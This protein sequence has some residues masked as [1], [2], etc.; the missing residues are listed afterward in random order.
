MSTL[1]TISPQHH[2]LLTQCATWCRPIN[3]LKVINQQF[4]S[5]SQVVPSP[6][7]TSPRWDWGYWGK[8]IRDHLFETCV[9]TVRR[10]AAPINYGGGR[11]V[12]TA[13]VGQIR[14]QMT[15]ESTEYQKVASGR[16]NRDPRL[17]TVKESS[18]GYYYE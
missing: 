10:E 9:H 2:W 15:P 17:V 4:N 6:L 1:I 12:I 16:T 11:L 3:L 14:P 18:R 13:T 8:I 5:R 7:T